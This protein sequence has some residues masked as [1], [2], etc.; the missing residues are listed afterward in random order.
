MEFVIEFSSGNQISAES[1]SHLINL[2]IK[3]EFIT[4]NSE[5]QLILYQSK[6]AICWPQLLK[7]E[8]LLGFSVLYHCRWNR[9]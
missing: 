8:N 7:C 2:S 1:F 6:N 3:E 9:V 5:N 4:T